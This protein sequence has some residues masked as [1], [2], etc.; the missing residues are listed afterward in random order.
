[1][2]L[3]KL[4]A[5]KIATEHKKGRYGDGGGLFLQVSEW[6][7]KAWVFRYERHGKER[8]MGLGPVQDVSVTLARRKAHEARLLI[9]AGKCAEQFL[10]AHAAGWADKN[11]IQWR[12]TLQLYAYPVMGDMPVGAV[13]TAAV[14][15]VLDPIWRSKSE[16]AKRLRARIASVLDSAT[17]LG[18]RKGDNPARWRGHLD[19]LLPKPGKVRAV[20]HLAALPHAEVPAFLTQLRQRGG[21]GAVALEITILTGVRTSEALGTKWTEIDLESATWTI[22]G[23][24]MKSRKEHR[25]PLSPRAVEIISGLPTTSEYLFP[26]Y[27]AGRPFSPLA[28]LATLRRLGRHDLTVHGFRSSFRDWAAE[29]TAYPNHVVEMALAHAIGDQVEAAYRRGDLF[30]KRR[31]LMADWSAHCTRTTTVDMGS[32][33]PIRAGATP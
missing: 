8:M 17:V 16:T 28:M 9:L 25:V 26:S 15:R 18:L 7:T 19:K 14:M 33:T 5:R 23:S 10:A 21:L 22:P 27:K 20:Q 29:T 4:S 32:V 31:R 6:G 2:A 3:N 30:D 12:T 11:L 13:D 1:M 24:R